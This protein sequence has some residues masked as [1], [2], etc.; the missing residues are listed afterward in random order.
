MKKLILLSLFI[1]SGYGLLSS[2]TTDEKRV[3]FHLSFFSPLST[4]GMQASQY[5]NSACINIQ[6]S[7]KEKNSLYHLI[8]NE[9]KANTNSH[10]PNK[11]VVTD[12]FSLNK[13]DYLRLYFVPSFP[14]DGLISYDIIKDFT[15]LFYGIDKQLANKYLEFKKEDLSKQQSKH[16]DEYSDLDIPPNEISFYK[17]IQDTIFEKF[18]PDRFFYNQFDVLLMDSNL[19]KF[20]PPPPS[21]KKNNYWHLDL[22][23]YIDAPA[24]FPKGKKG[25]F[26]YIKKHNG[27]YK[28]IKEEKDVA[29]LFKIDKSGEVEQLYLQSFPVEDSKKEILDI[30]GSFLKFKPATIDG[31]PV[32]SY[33]IFYIQN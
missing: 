31:T 1:I 4:N 30:W 26:N 27:L 2:Q 23:S 12:F 16:I 28:R 6:P 15:V 20:P 3:A 18:T 9:Y 21:V 11:I 7:N 5:T 32:P 25:L 24:R 14:L 19:I 10:S 8:Y 33:Y 13:Q 17:I 29:L 22:F